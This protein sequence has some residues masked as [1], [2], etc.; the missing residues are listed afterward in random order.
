MNQ[1]NNN[2]GELRPLV[3]RR[4]MLGAA[5]TLLLPSAKASAG[6]LKS[7]TWDAWERYLHRAQAAMA[8]RA[9]G[10]FLWTDESPER[11]RAIHEG[12]VVV[13][14]AAGGPMPVASGLIH[15]WMGAAFLPGARVA[16]VLGVIRDYDRYADFYKPTV[17]D[18]KTLSRSATED[19]F[20]IVA[21]DKAMFLKRAIEADY[22]SRFA[23]IDDGKWHSFAKT[24]RVQEI[25]E[26]SAR[27]IPEGEGSGYIWGMS[28]IWRYSERDGGVYIE[29]EAMALS[30][31][32]PA[33]LRFMV[34]PVVRRVSHATL[35][36]SLEQT[37][38]AV[39]GA[40]RPMWPTGEQR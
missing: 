23:Q 14:Q 11:L 16:N 25:Q 3:T 12:R 2:T 22:H 36:A 35:A 39:L 17:I 1:P 9:E 18:G 26:G 38:D 40:R 24:T 10:R 7:E 37:R 8:D 31:S 33:G 6:Q 5:F 13:A 15:R 32:I 30:R 21:V 29:S 19:R 20:S 4:A 28:T 27:R 34:D